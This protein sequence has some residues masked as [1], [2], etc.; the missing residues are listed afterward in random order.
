MSQVINDDCLSWMS[1]N[2]RDK[3]VDMVLC[4][5]PYGMTSNKWDSVID[6]DMLWDEY[7][8]V[9]KGTGVIVLTASQPFTSRLVSSNLGMFKHE[10]AWIKNRGSNFANTVREPMKE[11]ESVLVFANKKWIYN[12]QMQERAESGKSRAKYTVEHTSKSKNYRDFEGREHHQISEL[13]VPSSWQK[14]NIEVGLHPTQKPV[15][16]FEYLIKTYSNEGNLVLDNCAGSGTTGIACINTN[17]D[18]ILIEKDL[19]Y[20]NISKD[21]VEKHIKDS[22]NKYRI[23]SLEDTDLYWGNEFGWVDIDSCESFTEADRRS[24]NLPIGGH[25][26]KI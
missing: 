3:S 15:A 20:Y 4:D 6:L 17:R 19:G 24:L 9:I 10:W 22:I 8:R 5:L 25:W 11:H 1:R 18:Y 2:I 7:R 26:V 14:F 13:R 23:Q 12:R 16:L 21:R